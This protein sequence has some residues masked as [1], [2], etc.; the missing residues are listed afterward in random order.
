MKDLVFHVRQSLMA[1]VLIG[2]GCIAYVVCAPKVLG[3]FLFSLGL[4]TVVI[5]EKRLYTGKIG[6]VNRNTN[7]LEMLLMLIFNL[8]G[9]G[10]TCWLFAQYSGLDIDTAELVSKKFSRAW[11]EALMLSMG[12]G[13]MMYI[14]VDGYKKTKNYLAV[15]MPIMFFILC[16]F[17][18][19]IAN[20]GYMAMN[21]T[22]FHWNLLIW[23]VG[24]AIGSLILSR[25]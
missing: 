2:F 4:L 25:I 6:Y 20:F 16:G 11:Y 21:G 23:I 19:C 15:I 18:H 9:I 14:A 10:I 3:A 7:W 5:Q 24:N 12:C 1:G 17:E 8:V 13:V 22:F